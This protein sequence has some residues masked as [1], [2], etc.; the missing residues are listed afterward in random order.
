MITSE[1]NVS[2]YRSRARYGMLRPVGMCHAL[3]DTDRC[4][5]LGYFPW[6]IFFVYIYIWL[7]RVQSVAA[8]CF[9]TIRV[10]RIIFKDN[11]MNGWI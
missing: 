10:L 11:L 1:C 6:D 8:S 2:L 9:N 4:G 3:D 7:A 5:I